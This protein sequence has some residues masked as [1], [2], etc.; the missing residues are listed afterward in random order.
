MQKAKGSLAPRR[1]LGFPAREPGSRRWP[2]QRA[3]A[4]VKGGRLVAGLGLGDNAGGGVLGH[5]TRREASNMI[6]CVVRCTGERADTARKQS[7]T[8]GG[9]AAVT[10]RVVTGESTAS[11]FMA[12]DQG[13]FALLQ[14]DH[15]LMRRIGHGRQCKERGEELDLTGEQR[16]QTEPGPESGPGSSNASRWNRFHS[17]T[18]RRSHRPGWHPW[19]R[20]RLHPLPGSVAIHFALN[21]RHSSLESG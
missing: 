12:Q 8:V 16:R 1:R 21:L 2:S 6:E 14:A 19:R 15:N 10:P 9:V 20:Q 17:V 4:C 5:E 3:S 18:A 11:R 7:V 13:E